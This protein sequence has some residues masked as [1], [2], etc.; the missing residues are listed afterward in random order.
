GLAYATV[1]GCAGF[2]AV[3]GSS[4]ATAA[5]FGRIALPEMNK[6]GY[7]PSFA[8]GSVAAGGTLG[9]LVPPSGA[10]ILFALLTEESIATLFMAA[11]VPAL[12]ALLLYFAAITV[13]VR[14]NPD[15]APTPDTDI[16][17]ILPALIRALPVIL[18]F[19]L[20]IGGLY[21]GIF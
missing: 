1:A 9:A 15:A 7:S 14:M 6:R 16:E 5:T 21:G 4:V 8:T 18:L 2:G 17:P 19:T 20:V 13:V 3:S 11:V 12:L 10:I